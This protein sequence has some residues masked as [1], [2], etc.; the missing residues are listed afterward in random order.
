MTNN[1]DTGNSVRFDD[2]VASIIEN[3]RNGRIYVAD[4]TNQTGKYISV[5]IKDNKPDL[6][7]K[8]SSTVELRVT[9]IAGSSKSIKGIQITKV[10]NGSIGGKINISNLTFQ[11]ILQLLDLF[12][13]L[14]LGSIANRSIILDKSIINEKSQVLT[15]LRTLAM[16]PK[17]KEIFET[18]LEQS[19]FVHIE[20]IVNVA[21][22]NRAVQLFHDILNDEQ[23]FNEYKYRIGVGQNE[24]VW[25]Q[26]FSN[27]SW[28]LGSNFT[29]I[30]DQRKI[31]NENIAD[32][33]LNSYDGF[34]D[35]VEL[36]LPTAKWWTG[37]YIQTGELSKSIMQCHRYILELERRM[38]D[39]KFLNAIENKAII[40]PHVTLVYGRS[41][42]WD[43]KG[44][45]AYRVLS[46]SY[47]SLSIFTYDHL[48]DRAT[49]LLK[50]RPRVQS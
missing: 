16:D 20:D 22:K 27:H 31:D 47:H 38:N 12:T 3:K 8:I 2:D 18:F 5:T 49:Q 35:I 1:Q 32:Y 45:E 14:D 29:K 15:F 7:I 50:D 36:K 48:L 23:K 41:N 37:E 17:G 40:K 13:N 25:Q 46:S 44:K 10:K 21:Q 43:E 24:H 34:I 4:F 42:E 28:I 26:Y 11:K 9:Y 19:Q 39:V 6:T 33:I 30:L